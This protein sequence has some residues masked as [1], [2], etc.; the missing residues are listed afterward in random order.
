MK[1]PR[2]AAFPEK[3]FYIY[4]IVIGPAWAQNLTTFVLWF[5]S[6]IMI[7][8]HL[9][10][11]SDKE[12]M[13]EHAIIYEGEKPGWHVPLTRKRHWFYHVLTV[14]TVT[15]LAAMHW[16]WTGAL[17]LFASIGWWAF[18]DDVKKEMAKLKEETDNAG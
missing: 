2:W 11:R 5:L 4:A 13:M 1:F 7:V 9:M 14:A 10:W 18:V 17:Y 16:W 12:E 6:I 8:I 15:V 3:A